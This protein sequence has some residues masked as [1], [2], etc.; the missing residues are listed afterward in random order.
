MPRAKKTLI[1]GDSIIKGIN[2]RGLKNNVHCNISGAT[3]DVLQD[4]IFVYD[5]RNFSTIII[6]VGGNNVSNGS[7]IEYVDEKFDQ[8]LQYI[9]KANSDLSTVL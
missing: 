7:N 1:M 4:Q 3:V 6:Y 2:P 9:K 8:L 5:L